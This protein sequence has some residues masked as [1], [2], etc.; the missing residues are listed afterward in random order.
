[1][2]RIPDTVIEQLKSEVSLQRLVET[3]GIALKR[4]GADWLGLWPFHDDHE[5]SL[6]GRLSDTRI[7]VAALPGI[8]FMKSSA[9]HGNCLRLGAF[10][11]G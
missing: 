5:P 1:M 11:R 4:H 2:A 9:R 6:E 3:A 8:R 7:F 10:A